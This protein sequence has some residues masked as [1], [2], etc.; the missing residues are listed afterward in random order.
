MAD[1]AGGPSNLQGSF[2]RGKLSAG[3]KRRTDYQSIL[4]IKREPP[5][6]RSQGHVPLNEIFARISSEKIQ[7]QGWPA[8]ALEDTHVGKDKE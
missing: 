4:K 8:R 1:E 5:P 2:Q 7:D 3:Q 6:L